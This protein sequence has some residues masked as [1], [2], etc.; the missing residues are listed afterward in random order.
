MKVIAGFL[1]PKFCSMILRYVT[2]TQALGLVVTSVCF[3][4]TCMKG[5][6]S[7]FGLQKPRACLCNY[8]VQAGTIGKLCV[9]IA[10]SI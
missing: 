9:G 2:V 10:Q 3:Y 1:L 6:P 7:D 8:Q 5:K 4:L